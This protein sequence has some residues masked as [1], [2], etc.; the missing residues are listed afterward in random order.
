[1]DVNTIR[2]AITLAALFAYVGI[3][4]WAYTP[5]RKPGLDAEARRILNEIDE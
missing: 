2:I 5:G 1:M 3:V 4:L